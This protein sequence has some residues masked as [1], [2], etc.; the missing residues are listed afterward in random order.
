MTNSG[1]LK[2]I[3]FYPQLEERKAR[4]AWRTKLP[5]SIENERIIKDAHKFYISFGKLV[6]PRTSKLVD[7]L[8]DYQYD[9]WNSNAKSKLVIKSQKTGITTS[10]LLE[11]FQKT[12]MNP[13]YD[14][15]IIAQSEKAA[16]EHIGTLR[17]LIINSEKYR[18]YLITD[19]SELF[20]SDQKTKSDIIYI[21]NPLDAYRP[22][23]MIGLGFSISSAWSWKLVKHLHLSDPASANVV[24]D[25]Q[26]YA[27][28]LSRLTNTNGTV[29]IESPPKGVNNR[30]YELYEQYKNNKDKHWRVWKI[31][32]YD[33]EKAGLVTKEQIEKFRSELGVLFPQTYLAS[34]VIGTGDVFSPEIV[35]QAIE[36]GEQLKNVPISPYNIKIICCDPAYGGKARTAILSAEL[37]KDKQKI[38][39]RSTEE[40]SRPD[41]RDIARRLFELYQKNPMNNFILIDS[42]EAGLIKEC[43]I[44][45]KEDTDPESNDPRDHHVIS[46]NFGSGYGKEMLSNLRMLLYKNLIGIPKENQDLI[47]QLYTAKVDNS[48]NLDKSS[49]SLDLVDCMRMLTKAYFLK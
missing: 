33:A 25:S 22:S 44:Y 13:G 24:D 9:I 3:S 18:K 2:K 17:N 42:S 31:D 1:P 23:R 15:L 27:G 41:P 37:L 34:F 10:T 11:D 21:K 36:L 32:I 45:F 46:I 14:T 49:E 19:S 43:R 16:K 12:L 4:D 28:L 6:H 30:L 38:I 26:I 20:F 7:R 47:K 5:Y 8:A 39:I 40:H 35:E 29:I 48:F